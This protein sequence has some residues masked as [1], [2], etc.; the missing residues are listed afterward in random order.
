[1]KY[2]NTL[3]YKTINN[4]LMFINNCIDKNNCIKCKKMLDNYNKNINK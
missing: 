1:M 3:Q 2:K 4:D